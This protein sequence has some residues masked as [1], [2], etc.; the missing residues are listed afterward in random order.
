MT[1][2]SSWR[3]AS[4]GGRRK[5]RERIQLFLFHEL[6]SLHVTFVRLRTTAG[7]LEGRDWLMV[8]AALAFELIDAGSKALIG[9]A[10]IF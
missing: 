6:A 2:L 8:L 10:T 7:V 1:S 4:R 9:A 3:L 5:Q